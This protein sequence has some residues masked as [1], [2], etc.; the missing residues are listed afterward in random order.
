MKNNDVKAAFMKVRRSVGTLL[1]CV[2]SFALLQIATAPNASAGTILGSDLINFALLGGDGVTVN[3][4]GTVITG[5]VGACCNAS[6]VTGYPAG[7]TDSDGTVYLAANSVTSAAQ[8]ELGD[9]ITFL[10]GLAG[11]STSESTLNNI[12]LGPGVYS[13]SATNFNGTLTLNGGGDPDA[14]WVFLV[15]SSLTTASSSVIDL[16]DT[17]SGAGVYWVMGASATLGSDS[18]FVGN[19]LAPTAINVGTDVTDGCGSLLTQTAAVT[20]S[21]TDTIG[22]GCSGG[23]LATSAIPE[24]GTFV[25][26]LSGIQALSLLTF[27]RSRVDR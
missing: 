3:G 20:L 26:L 6:A 25:L 8:T 22:I 7:F 4:T 18:T 11:S 2:M 23:T 16:I 1:L 12:S 19:I 17:G 27:R 15:S 13:V 9:A 14:S 21:G 5:S 24:P 10:N